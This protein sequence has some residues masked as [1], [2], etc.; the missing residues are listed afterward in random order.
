MG[1]AFVGDPSW[2]LISLPVALVWF[3][4]IPVGFVCG[5]LS[6]RF[7]RRDLK[8]KAFR[9]GMA[10]ILTGLL[11]LLPLVFLLLPFDSKPFFVG[12]MVSTGVYIIVGLLAFT[13]QTISLILLTLPGL[14]SLCLGIR[15]LWIWADE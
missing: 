7:A 2:L 5:F 8:I 13:N 1:T 15:G 12:Y 11:L 3:G 4:A 10:A 6:V 9:A 14:V